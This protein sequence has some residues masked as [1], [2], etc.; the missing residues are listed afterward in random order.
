MLAH[1]PRPLRGEEQTYSRSAFEAILAA[2]GWDDPFETPYVCRGDG[3][4]LKHAETAELLAWHPLCELMAPGSPNPLDEPWLKF[5]F[6]ARQLAALMTYGYGYFIQEKYGEWDGGPNEEE[7]LSIGLLGGKA[8][9]VLRAAYVAY[10]HAA[11][12]APPLDQ[13]LETRASKLTQQYNEA[14]EAAMAR[15]KLRAHRHSDVEYTARLARVNDAVAELGQSMQDARKVANFAYARWR[16]AVVQHLLLPI[17]KVPAE[18]F[19][20]LNLQSVQP[21]RR[22]EALRQMQSLRAFEES[23]E[24]RTQWDLMDEIGGVEREIQYWQLFNAQNITEAGRR[25]DELKELNARLAALNA[26]MNGIDRSGG[27]NQPPI[28]VAQES[29][30]D[31]QMRRLADLRAFGG[32]WVKRGGRWG[33][34][35]KQSGSFG[36]LVEQEMGNG[37]Q[38]FSAKSVRRDLCAAAEADA[39]KK[40]SGVMLKGLTAP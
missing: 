28:D 27:G 30:T 12:L 11:Q 31:R 6:T 16:R 15:E 10:R 1:T 22:A 8:R 34:R 38:N 21:D 2:M 39:E 40:R 32:E 18:A 20:C 17:E 19:A 25:K 9:E 33:A 7:L 26:R 5:P 37:S 29:A 36:R 14:R 24:G 4:R 23:A 13:S 3:A 35:D